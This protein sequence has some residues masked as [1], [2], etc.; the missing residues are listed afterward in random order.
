MVSEEWSGIYT[1]ARIASMY[2]LK[3]REVAVSKGFNQSSLSRASDISFATIRRIWR[4]PHYDISM[5]TLA[6]IAKA[7]QVDIIELIETE[8]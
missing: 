1:L 6:K 4:D 8:R 7:L 2:R 5:S 3:V